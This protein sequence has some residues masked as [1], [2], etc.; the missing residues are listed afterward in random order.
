MHTQKLKTKKDY[1]KQFAKEDIYMY[2]YIYIYIYIYIVNVYKY[3]KYKK[4]FPTS[5]VIIEIQIKPTVSTT[6]RRLEWL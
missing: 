2:A 6:R 4:R 1:I 3:K 5:L